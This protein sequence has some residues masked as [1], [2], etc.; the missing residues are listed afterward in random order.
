MRAAREAIYPRNG[1]VILPVR[2]RVDFPKFV[3]RIESNAFHVDKWRFNLLELDLSPQYQASQ[4]QAANRGVKHLGILR[5]R[6]DQACAIGA[7][8]FKLH[9][10][11]AKGSGAVVILPVYVI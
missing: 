10:V 9:N 6:T 2:L 3:E 11:A 8:E 4:A 5:W 1:V 7:Q